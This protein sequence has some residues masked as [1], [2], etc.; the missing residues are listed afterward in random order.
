VPVRTTLT[1]TLHRLTASA[2]GGVAGLVLDSLQ[3][4]DGWANAVTG[5]GTR[6]DK[7]THTHFEPSM[8]LADQEL[9]NLYTFDDLAARVVDA[10]PREEWRLGFGLKGIAPDSVNDC[11]K[12]FR[13]FDV[14]G[15]CLAARI[16]GRLYGGCAIWAI[17]DD[18]LTP[19]QPLNRDAIRTVHGLR[20]IDRRFLYP[21]TWYTAQRIA[22]EGLPMA[23]LGMPE[24]YR[25]FVPTAGGGEAIIGII[26]ESRLVRFP[27]ERTEHLQKVR[28]LDWDLS[29][30]QKAHDALSQTGDTWRA[31]N[32]L[33]QD[34]N[35]GVY[36][37]Q[38]L[39]DMVSDDVAQ[40]DASG[41]DPTGGGALL[42]R[43]SIM[44]QLRST[45]RAIVLDK[46][47]EDFART[48]TTFTGLP[49]LSDRGWNRLAACSEIPVPVL[50]GQAP[51]GLNATGDAVMQW[52]FAK[53][54]ANRTQID[55]PALLDLLGILLSA[56]DA[57]ELALPEE[58]GKGR[59]DATAESG[60][61]KADPLDAI[62]IVWLPLWA[63]TAKELSEIRLARAQEAQIYITQQ[64][65]LPEEVALGMPED[66]WSF[67]RDWRED[68]LEQEGAD[69]LDQQREAKL[70]P[71]APV[72][73][74]PAPG[75]PGQPPAQ[76]PLKP[77]PAQAQKEP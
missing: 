73:A 8:L 36:K 19:D 69:M 3:R 31:I 68:S 23:K 53:V 43:A 20:V 30:L 28:R 50:T 22:D 1:R 6:R 44:D 52:W 63:P 61:E 70:N 57:P 58:P 7:T 77:P 74:P 67:R 29:V 13:R 16:W 62:G 75:K 25:V 45:L 64:V 12:Y 49:E 38:N 51:A 60:S 33:V 41:G 54:D 26:H 10:Y 39:Y 11:A 24:T 37:I 59:K 2:A 72:I 76:Q 47:K 18:G 46:D 17:V 34:A 21:A 15:V 5:F 32:I 71:P 48:P 66:W 40:G 42:K 55:E 56:Q 14:V 65:L 4:V 9:S 27:G 35:Q